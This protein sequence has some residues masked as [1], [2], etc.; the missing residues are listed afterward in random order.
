MSAEKTVSPREETAWAQ[1]LRLLMRRRIVVVGMALVAAAFLV[2][3]L[4]PLLTRHNPMEL[5]IAARL[6]APSRVNLFGTDSFGRDVFSRVVYGARLSIL[7]GAMSVSVAAVGGGLI[8]LLAGYYPRLDGI[9]MR[10]MDGIMAFPN[11]VLAIALMASLGPSVFNVIVSLGF[12]YMPRVARVVRSGVLVVRESLH[13][14]AAR[15]LGAGD[16]RIL[17]LNIL[18]N[19]FSPIIVQATFVFA[20]AVLGEAALSFL[21]VG[22][23]PYISSWG[24]I[25]SEGRQFITQAPWITMFPGA[26]IMLT[27]LGLNV[28][29]DGLR[30]A[31]DPRMRYVYGRL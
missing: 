18:P 31:F 15:A 6:R 17:R 7:V 11:I 12:V 21:G 19:C 29:G 22:I 20:Y 2:A 8:G 23:P 27:V 14:E 28:V 13:V 9:L 10:V 24:N 5:E 3:L 1:T 30:D 16:A 4:A 26:A 25:L